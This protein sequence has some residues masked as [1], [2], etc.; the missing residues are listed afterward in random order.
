MQGQIIW[1]ETK[2]NGQDYRAYDLTKLK[3]L[4]FQCQFSISRGLEE[5]ISWYNSQQVE[6]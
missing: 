2:P 3:S 6:K 4:N 1:D 5:T